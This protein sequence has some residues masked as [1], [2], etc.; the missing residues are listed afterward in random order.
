MAIKLLQGDK[1]TIIRSLK[2]LA[3][4]LNV[5]MQTVPSFSMKIEYSDFVAEEI[6][7]TVRLM[8]DGKEVN[9][10]TL[11][12][13]A[14]EL[15]TTKERLFELCD[16]LLIPCFSLACDNKLEGMRI[17]SGDF[18]YIRKVLAG[19]NE[20]YAPD[21]PKLKREDKEKP[22]KRLTID[23]APG[24]IRPY[25]LL[26][27]VVEGTCLPVKTAQDAISCV[28]GE[29][30]WDYS[31]VSDEDWLEAKKIVFPRLKKLYENNTIRFGAYC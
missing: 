3:A 8:Q 10:Y 1:A 12:D 7:M 15:N 26:P 25:D 27:Q 30:V 18:E 6:T 5:D 17:S 9:L 19:N 4:A 28:F 24:G 21:Y 29:W 13:S 14:K 22:E 31:E 11:E 23:C 20:Y 2:D 16:T